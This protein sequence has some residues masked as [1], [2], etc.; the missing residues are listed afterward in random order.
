MSPSSASTAGQRTD[1]AIDDFSQRWLEAL[2]CFCKSD[3]PQWK[4]TQN[5]MMCFKGLPL[6]HMPRKLQR[7]IDSCFARI[8]DVLAG[9]T[10]QTWDDYQQISAEDLTR[11][12]KLIEN[13]PSL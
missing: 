5:A 4:R 10:L 7:Q 8:N 3:T 1:Q 9:Y 13:I 12:E 11:I 6:D 2:G